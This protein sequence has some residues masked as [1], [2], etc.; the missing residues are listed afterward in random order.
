MCATCALLMPS[1]PCTGLTHLAEERHSGGLDPCQRQSAGSNVWAANLEAAVADMD[2]ELSGA[3]AQPG[4]HIGCACSTCIRHSA[5][6]FPDCTLES[7]LCENHSMH[8]APDQRLAQQPWQCMQAGG[9][10]RPLN[11][12]VSSCSRHRLMSSLLQGTPCGCPCWGRSLR[13]AIPLGGLSSAR[14]SAGAL[15]G[16]SHRTAAGRPPRQR[17][18]EGQHTT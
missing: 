13:T 6:Y 4:H 5:Q 9:H 15:P 8:T 1:R 7:A 18:R 2:H 17:C 10:V 16:R 14:S 11:K 3:L 12:K